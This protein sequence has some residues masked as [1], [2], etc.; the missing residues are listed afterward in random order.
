MSEE[1]D[2]VSE[3]ETLIRA[4]FTAFN[5]KDFDEL[6]DLLSEDVIHDTPDGK[7]EYGKAA[8]QAH[9]E[10]I[11]RTFSRSTDDLAVMLSDDGRRAAAEFTLIGTYLES[12][13]GLPPAA[14][15]SFVLPGAMLFVVVEGEITRVTEYSNRN[16]LLRQLG[17]GA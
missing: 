9:L 16:D 2:T 3:S 4:F 11:N 13:E 10:R 15:Q 5:L 14:N 8:Y 1:A 12:A 7:R 17:A 6:L